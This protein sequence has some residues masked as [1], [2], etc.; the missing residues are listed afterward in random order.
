MRI[1]GLEV[2]RSCQT[3][4]SGAVGDWGTNDSWERISGRARIA[5][6]WLVKVAV[7]AAIYF[8]SEPLLDG[9]AK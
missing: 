8:S 7:D 1:I 9:L 2:I 3:K 4:C 5:F 6:A